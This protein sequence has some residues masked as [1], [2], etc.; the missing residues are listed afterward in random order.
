M[1]LSFGFIMVYSKE[2]ILNKE[3]L[4]AIFYRKLL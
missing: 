4:L 2:T 3:N 1:E